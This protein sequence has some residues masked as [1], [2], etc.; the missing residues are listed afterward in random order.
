VNCWEIIYKVT[1]IALAILCAI[2]VVC[3]FIPKV[4]QEHSLQA[5]KADAQ[6]QNARLEAS[7]KDLKE[8]QERFA[9]EPA[10]V[11]QTARDIGM[12]KTNETLFK[13]TN[14]PPGLLQ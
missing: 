4:R 10:F 6:E 5:K 12:V 7:L 14:Q 9:T 1:W 11:E 8:K 2:C 13:F 3:M